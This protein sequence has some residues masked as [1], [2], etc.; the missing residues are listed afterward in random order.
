VAKLFWLLSHSSSPTN[1]H[2]TCLTF[3]SPTARFSRFENE[4]LI[5]AVRPMLAVSGGDCG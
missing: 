3:R 1:S 4:V 2:N 5:D